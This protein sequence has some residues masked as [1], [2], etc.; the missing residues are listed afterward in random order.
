ML[1]AEK[2]DGGGVSSS[3]NEL[4][5]PIYNESL[6]DSNSLVMNLRTVVLDLSHQP[7]LKPGTMLSIGINT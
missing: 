7:L 3:R 6:L 4:C 2:I 5:A 1:C